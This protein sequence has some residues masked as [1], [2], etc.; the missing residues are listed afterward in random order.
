MYLFVGTNVGYFPG[1]HIIL[2]F[3]YCDERSIYLV[4]VKVMGNW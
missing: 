3:C 1:N 2:K 4:A